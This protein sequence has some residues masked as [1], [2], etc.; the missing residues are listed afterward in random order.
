MVTGGSN[1]HERA[2]GPERTDP[3]QYPPDRD[4]NPGRGPHRRAVPADAD[5][6]VAGAAPLVD[7]RGPAPHRPGQRRPAGRSPRCQRS[8]ADDPPGGPARGLP[9][10]RFPPLPGLCQ[11]PARAARPASAAGRRPRAADGCSAASPSGRSAT[12]PGPSPAAPAPAPVGPARRAGRY[13]PAPARPSRPALRRNP[14][15]PVARPR[16]P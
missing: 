13:W 7:H 1:R 16:A 8:A 2:A 6:R 14:R 10:A 3:R 4:R 5:A 9:A 15:C 12:S 11:P